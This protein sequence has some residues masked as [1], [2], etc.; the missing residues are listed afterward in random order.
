MKLSQLAKRVAKRVEEATTIDDLVEYL[1][2]M[3][4]IEIPNDGDYILSYEIALKLDITLTREVFDSYHSPDE[5]IIVIKGLN[6]IENYTDRLKSYWKLKNLTFIAVF[7]EKSNN[8]GFFN[9]FTTI[10]SKAE[11]YYPEF[12]GFEITDKHVFFYHNN[13]KNLI[14]GNIYKVELGHI[15]AHNSKNNPYSLKI[16]KIS[17]LEKYFGR[18]HKTTYKSASFDNVMYSESG[19][20]LMSQ[21]EPQKVIVSPSVSL[22]EGIYYS[23]YIDKNKAELPIA[24]PST[25]EKLE[26]NPYQNY[27]RL[28]FER[29]NNPEA[30]RMIANLMR[31]IGKGMYSS[32]QRMIFELLQ[33]ADD[34]PCKEKVEF[35]IDINGDYFFVMHNG[36]PF[37]MDDVEAITSAAESTK[38]GDNKKTGYKGIGFKSV[39]TDSME[40]WL[41]SGG[42]QFAFIRNSVLFE[43]FDK[44]Y[45][46][47]ERY[48]KY[49]DLLEQDKLAYRNQ[50]QRFNG[51]KDIPWQ[52]IPIWQ[53]K[54]PS[55]FSDTNYKEHPNPV[56][57]A[58][59]IGRIIIEEYKSAVDNIT[60]RPQFLLFLRNTSKFA[61]PKNGV[62]VTRNDSGNI[63]DIK[64]SKIVFSNSK[65]EQRLDIFQ[66]TKQTYEDISVTNKAFFN[67]NI[68][69]KKQSKTND[70][71]EVTHYFTDLA[72]RE[73]ETIPPKLALATETEI[74]FG[75]SLVDGKISPEKEYI[76]E[77]PKYSSLFTYLPMED[78]RFQLPFLVNADFVPSSDRQKIQG[79]SLWNRYIMIKVAEKHVATISHYAQ[80]FIEDN[81]RFCSYLSLLLK[82]MIPE[83]DTAQQIIDSYNEKYL[84]QLTIKPI[85]VNDLNLTQRLY[86][87]I[88][89]STGLTELFGNDIFYEIINTQKRL[90]HF[91]LDSSY[92]KKYNYLDVENIDLGTLAKY[93]TPEICSHLGEIIAKNSLHEKPELL[94]WLDKIEPFITVI[95]NEI[96]FIKHNN[97]F[98]SVKQIILEEGVWLINKN[99][100]QCEDFING[101]GYHVINLNFIKHKNIGNYIDKL[102][103]YINN[104]KTAYER[105]ASNPTL[106][107]LLIPLKLKL[108]AFF[109]TSDFMVGVGESNYFE[110]LKLFVDENGIARPLRQLIHRKDSIEITSIKPFKINAQEYDSLSLSLKNEL[111]IKNNI[112]TS[113][114]LK[115]QLFNEWSQQF[116]SEN[117]NRYVDDLKA[118]FSWKDEGEAILQSKWADIPWLYIDDESKFK[119]TE[120]VFWSNAFQSLSCKNYQTI[121]NIFHQS[122]LK[123][124]P[125][126]K[127]GDIIKEFNLNTDDSSNID[128]TK[129]DTLE[130]LSANT[131]LDWME[132]DG[133]YS[134]FF[135]E[136]TLKTNENGLWFILKI[137][138]TKIFDGSNNVLKSYI[139]SN[140][141]LKILFTELD[142]SLCCNNRN[143]IGLL[144]GDKL[145]K[146][147]IDSKAF[148]QNLAKFLPS[149]ISK[150]LLNNFILNLPVF[151]L[152]TGVT[153]NANSPEHII[154][155]KLLRDVEDLDTITAEVQ[156]VIEKLRCKI[157][158][159][160]TPLSNYDLSDRIQ[161]SWGDDK[162]VLKLSDV[163]EEF[164]G[165]SDV[166]D[167]L[168]ES[169]IS[170]SNKRKLRELIFKTRQMR[171]YEVCSKIEDETSEYYT[172][173]QT[174]FQLLDK[175]IGQ[176]KWDKEYFDDYWGKQNNEQKLYTSYNTFL[177]ILYDLNFSTL[178][179]FRFYDLELDHCV[180][181]NFAIESEKAPQWLIEWVNSDMDNRLNFLSKL[182]YNHTNSPIILL[183]QSM[184]ANKY[185]ETTVISNLKNVENKVQLLKNTIIWLSQFN[186]ALITRNIN[187][188][189]LINQKIPKDPKT[190]EEAVAIPV[191][192]NIDYN[193]QK[194]Y[195]LQKIKISENLL[196]LQEDS[197]FLP[198]VFSLIHEKS[199]NT[200]I[201]DESIGNNISCF[202]NTDELK[203]DDSLFP[204]LTLKDCVIKEWAIK[205]EYLPDWIDTW[206][207]GK[208]QREKLLSSLGYNGLNSP[209]VKLREALISNKFDP[210]LIIGHYAAAKSNTEIVWNTIEWLSNFGSPIVTRN[211]E[212][213]KQINNDISLISNTLKPII[214]PNIKSINNDG[215]RSYTLQKTEL[216]SN[217]FY[218]VEGEE[219]A[220][221]IYTAIKDKDADA[222]F[223]D[224]SIGKKSSH[225]NIINIQL[226]KTIDTEKL[227]QNSKIWEE[228]FYKK[229]EHYTKYPIYIYNGNEIPYVRT[230]KGI[231]INTYTQ[232]LK[233]QNGHK[234]YVSNIFK[235]DITEQLPASFPKDILTN[236]KEW[237]RKT[238]KE[239]VLI[240]DNPFEEKYNE[241]FDRMIQD[242]YG[243][244]EERQNDENSNAKRQALYYL[245]DKGYEI[246]EGSSKKNYS[247]IYDIIDPK[248]RKHF[249]CIVRSARGGLLYLDKKHWDMLED[250]RMYLI[251]IYPG[252]SPRIFKNR[253]ELLEEELAEKVLFRVPNNKN[254]SEIDG[255][256]D[257]LES[258]SHLILVTSEKMKESLFSKLKQN[259]DFKKEENVA[260]GGDDFRL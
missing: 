13:D 50:R 139:Y 253:L 246:D 200:I 215:I 189:K 130:T 165:E 131:L 145:L 42:Y 92:L 155:H 10:D 234:Y 11:I 161:F 119:T 149:S 174:V 32:K 57:F 79:D 81:N 160:Q 18:Y 128:W 151:N 52:V 62:T 185:D 243:I 87:T 75:I 28:R 188:I 107:K 225:F 89:D 36:A 41:K 255:V 187:I 191:I 236:L 115:A 25:I 201:V 224:G 112:F 77:L 220:N 27:I 203:I 12:E 71:N 218:L 250:S 231:T 227:E 84:E 86:E 154:V 69:L 146:E 197:E 82:K 110:K 164:K 223:V 47:R 258:E 5:N 192:T 93:I 210:V 190:K 195:E 170:I 183:R 48:K 122:E 91:N 104:N 177:D 167:E 108:I 100:I 206:K 247:A 30:N 136:H 70:F 166:L 39:F 172:V 73:I 245:K 55:E 31:E 232:D 58:L 257:S 152:K 175:S 63:I 144:Q 142:E 162:K 212:L 208:P 241:T 8:T 140:E 61:F 121:K 88:I 229:W 204:E 157:Q 59:K 53:D 150:E 184:K 181:R 214:I 158:I 153:Y 68:G 221:S 33:N 202:K 217:L 60:K 133:G 180:D 23:F 45:F 135:E 66:Y 99:T 95:F 176:K 16:K 260:V 238:L 1:K 213:I 46:S 35:H 240:E 106:P 14:D 141:K 97:S 37:N 251:V 64:K 222:L 156:N 226:T 249:N 94:E 254:I 259:R 228:P 129:T 76:D 123:I 235:N 248:D 40:V 19:N 244:S 44:F 67:L 148:D 209:I 85:V 242:R 173:H 117:I 168:I 90:P 233:V 134:D 29:L 43:D 2:K 239:P 111:I 199:K 105:I 182:G 237:E 219:Y 98:L 193:C 17:L 78:T 143:K 114:I 3:W 113:F 116:N 101:L 96:P 34:A 179:G 138:D 4:K 205:L 65:E 54:L 256:F 169:F 126:K 6:N 194:Y 103:G 72:G 125:L 252:N 132:N 7:K 163:L 21:G 216:K 196:I 198:E 127:C 83:D 137:E 49:P 102:P 15:D 80:E 22:L 20:I 211:I 118:I 9:H 24:I 56:Q 124:L 186:S 38:K 230:F 178:D 147:I 207:K 26:L 120:K 159:N 109:Q 171:P 74:S 51:S